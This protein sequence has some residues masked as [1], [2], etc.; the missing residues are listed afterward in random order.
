MRRLT[1]LAPLVGLLVACDP[2][3]FDPNAGEEE[4][5]PSIRIT[6]P[7]PGL[8]N[9]SR[10]E[11]VMCPTFTVVVE[12][13]NFEFSHDHYDGDPIEG[14][15][16]WHLHVDDPNLETADNAMADP[17]SGLPNPLEDGNH[18]IY[19]VLVQNNHLRLPDAMV[20][21]TTPQDVHAVEITVSDEMG[22]IGGGNTMMGY[23]DTGDSG[24]TDTGS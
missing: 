4:V 7:N 10:D 19:A 18:T 5:F 6:F 17:Y 15:G 21:P 11:M 24:A 2:P 8:A 23:G 13:E 16:H 3:P 1:V 12:H 14:E 9:S 20:D 22:C